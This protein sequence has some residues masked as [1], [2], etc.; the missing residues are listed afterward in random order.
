MQFLDIDLNEMT[1]IV[2]RLY[3]L[4]NYCVRELEYG[5]VSH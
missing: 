4:A 1:Q 2:N 5:E 3:K